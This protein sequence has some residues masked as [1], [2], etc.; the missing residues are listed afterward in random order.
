VLVGGVVFVEARGAEDGDAGANEVEA[1]EAG[2]EVANDFEEEAEFFEAA[3]GAA[4]EVAVIDFAAV[5]FFGV[6][7][8]GGGGESWGEDGRHGR[9]AGG[10]DATVGGAEVT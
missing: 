4:D 10:G 8:F 2:E 6:F 7:V 5:G 1:A 3:V 9:V